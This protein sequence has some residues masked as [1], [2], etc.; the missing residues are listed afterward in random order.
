[1]CALQALVTTIPQDGQLSKSSPSVPA[2]CPGQ[3]LSDPRARKG[4]CRQLTEKPSSRFF[5]ALSS[6]F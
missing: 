6:L 1:M 5:P 2:A 4:S 3:A